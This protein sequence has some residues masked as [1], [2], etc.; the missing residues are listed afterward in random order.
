MEARFIYRNRS[1]VGFYDASTREMRGGPDKVIVYV[2]GVLCAMDRKA[3]IVIPISRWKLMEIGVACFLAAL[4]AKG[5]AP[6]SFESV[7]V[8]EPPPAL[9]EAVDEHLV[10]SLDDKRAS[11]EAT[12]Q[13]SSEAQWER[14]IRE[15]RDLSR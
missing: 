2:N 3:K 15:M 12:H 6:S 5:A 9:P 8:P 14:L 7:P 1:D 11:P 4:K 10:R 13:E